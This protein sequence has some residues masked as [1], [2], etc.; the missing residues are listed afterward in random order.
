MA[1]A[2]RMHWALQW[3]VVLL[4]LPQCAGADSEEAA[5]GVDASGA[6]VDDTGEFELLAIP[7]HHLFPLQKDQKAMWLRKIAERLQNVVART[8]A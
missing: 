2:P 4:L 8:A 7:G 3:C 6:Q 1:A 5:V